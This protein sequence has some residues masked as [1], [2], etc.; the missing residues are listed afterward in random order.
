MRGPN[1]LGPLRPLYGGPYDPL[2]DVRTAPPTAAITD[3]P[4]HVLAFNAEWSSLVYGALERIQFTDVFDANATDAIA[5]VEQIIDMLS[6]GGAS[7]LYKLSL[8]ECGLSLLRDDVAVSTV[9][10]DVCLLAVLERINDGESDGTIGLIRDEIIKLIDNP[11]PA[12]DQPLPDD[13]ANLIVNCDPDQLFAAVR[14]MNDYVHQAVVDLIEM[15]NL[16]LSYVQLMTEVA[17]NVVIV[18]ESAIVAE[19]IT[20]LL[21]YPLLQYRAAY[22]Q[23]LADEISC[24][25]FCLAKTDCDLSLIDAMR[26]HV[27][28]SGALL[29]LTPSVDGVLQAA[30][31]RT[32][33]FDVVHITHAI[34]YASALASARFM[35]IPG[36]SAM[37]TAFRA[38]N[39]D[40]DSDWQIL[41]S[42]CYAW[43][44]VIPM[45]HASIV[46]AVNAY[47][48]QNWG[49]YEGLG[50]AASSIQE[51]Q[52]NAKQNRLEF[53][54][55]ISADAGT[56]LEQLQFNWIGDVGG[57][58]GG[59][60]IT[61][62]F[63]GA[64]VVTAVG[65]S[66]TG[67]KEEWTGVRNVGDLTV[68]GRSYQTVL[69][70]GLGSITISGNGPK[71]VIA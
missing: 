41:C 62:G 40:S 23:A 70:F 63:A 19:F 66:L 61:V 59:I 58:G 45:D 71:P 11:L 16:A 53:S 39:N 55:A 7:G 46:Y 13:G 37:R 27:N 38:F 64:A 20:W 52:P 26:Y 36:G 68:V 51:V 47:T 31:N 30:I 29:P 28:E 65:A 15:L 5:A 21:E 57:P 42:T 14:Q 22:T 4:L 10:L 69:P 43:T 44:L 1:P 49:S 12:P 56:T 3:D 25:L 67:K 2:D 54:L 60:G 35:K 32:T 34:V 48:E 17:D 24:D 8:D 33:G 6:N 18:Q 9:S 50:Y